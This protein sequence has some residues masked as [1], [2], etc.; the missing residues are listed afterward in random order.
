MRLVKM[1]SEP[2]FKGV[3]TM[4]GDDKNDLLGDDGEPMGFFKRIYGLGASK[5]EAKK[6]DEHKW[7]LDDLPLP[8]VPDRLKGVEENSIGLAAKREKH[9]FVNLVEVEKEYWSHARIQ[10]INEKIEVEQPNYNNTLRWPRYVR[11]FFRKLRE[12]STPLVDWPLH[13]T[14]VRL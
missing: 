6:I 10:R 3:N 8:I 14:H 1:S 13:V 2:S 11:Q 7:A 12:S 4:S 9:E 5:T